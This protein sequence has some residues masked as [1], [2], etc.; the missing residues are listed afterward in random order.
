MLFGCDAFTHALVTPSSLPLCSFPS[1]TRLNL[2]APEP[3]LFHPPRYWSPPSACAF[4]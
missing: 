2:H 3:L 4:A 1:I